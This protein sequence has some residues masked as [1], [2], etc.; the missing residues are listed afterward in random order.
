[1]PGIIAEENLTFVLGMAMNIHVN[2]PAVATNG[3]KRNMN[4]RI[5]SIASKTDA[6]ISVEFKKID[7]PDVTTTNTGTSKRVIR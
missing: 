5:G 7:I 2:T 1:M 6:N 4:L 3:I